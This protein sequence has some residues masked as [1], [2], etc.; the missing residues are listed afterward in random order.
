MKK[1]CPVCRKVLPFDAYLV[2]KMW[3]EGEK[4]RVH[5]E[6]CSLCLRM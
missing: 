3:N 2:G 6:G 4:T 1:I 5:V